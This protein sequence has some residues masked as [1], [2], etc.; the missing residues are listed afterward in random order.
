MRSCF[1]GLTAT[2]NAP[3][4]GRKRRRSSS[5]KADALEA[6]ESMNKRAR[7]ETPLNQD[8]PSTSTLPAADNE[9]V[10]EVTK[11]VKEFEL[12]DGEKKTQEDSE[13]IVASGSAP[14]V[15]PES[16]P[17]P[18]EEAGELDSSSIASTPPPD[19]ETQGEKDNDAVEEEEGST[20]TEG[21]T[22]T[23]EAPSSDNETRVEDATEKVLEKASE[24]KQDELAEVSTGADTP[25]AQETP[26]LK[27]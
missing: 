16:V 24:S 15:L 8:E 17:L 18:E 13:K 9:G 10:K 21:E 25:T 26:D 11:G 2:S 6:A 1:L 19:G 5:D 12:E 4:I 23:K 3:K 22:A 27:D 7:G 20:G 14:D